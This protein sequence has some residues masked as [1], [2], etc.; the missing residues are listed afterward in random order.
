MALFDK[1]KP[2]L[3]LQREI[4]ALLD[5]SY[6]RQRRVRKAKKIAK[7]LK[8]ALEA[9]SLSLSERAIL[10][11]FTDLTTPATRTEVAFRSG[12]ELHCPTVEDC[13]DSLVEKGLL[14]RGVARGSM[15]AYFHL[16]SFGDAWLK[17][18]GES[19]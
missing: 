4:E 3:R 6:P 15:F 9:V 2:S 11:S 18:D 8:K 19:S 5:L 7:R 10:S 13:L 12:F 17:R 14:K 1:R 16:T